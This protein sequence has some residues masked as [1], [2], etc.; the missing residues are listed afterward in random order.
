VR[1]DPVTATRDS[2]SVTLNNVVDTIT[3]QSDGKILVGGAFTVVQGMAQSYFVR[4]DNDTA[5]T[6]SLA[7]TPST[8]VWVVGGSSPQFTRATFELSSN[9]VDYSFLGCPSA[10]S[11]HWTLNGLN[12]PMGQ[13]LYVRARGYYGDDNG[14]GSIIESVYNVM[15]VPQPQL[16][17]RLS[18]RTNAVLFWATNAVGFNLQSTTNLN[19]SG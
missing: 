16:N 3:L 15:A 12:L 19:G 9:S 10:S 13:N 17:L 14:S 8:I 2:F 7:A 18:A 1:L 4:L 5:A 6:R 11:A